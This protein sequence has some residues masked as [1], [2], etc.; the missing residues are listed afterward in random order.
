[1]GKCCYYH[2]IVGSR[3]Y[4]SGGEGEGEELK[5]FL[6]ELMRRRRVLPSQLATG[7]GISHATISRWLSGRDTPSVKS[8]RKL[9]DYDEIPVERVLTIAGHLPKTSEDRPD[10]LPVFR[11][12]ARQKY[13]AELDEDLIT[14]IDDLIERRR[15][16]KLD[17][18]RADSES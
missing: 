11:E 15:R 16:R 5:S 17:P 6:Q 10:R 9:A 14:M 4:S 3:N 12:Y 8:C 7:L 13:S 1:M 18:N 2:D